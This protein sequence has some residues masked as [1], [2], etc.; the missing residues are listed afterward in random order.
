MATP[1]LNEIEIQFARLSSEAQLSLLDRL[2]RRV[3]VSLSD[4]HEN[5]D[6]ELSA[7]AADPQ[8]QRELSQITAE[9]N[10]TE[11]DGLERR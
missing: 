8:M 5:W 7:M 11:D 6:A 10:V 2:K 9:F 4:P 1:V 3:R